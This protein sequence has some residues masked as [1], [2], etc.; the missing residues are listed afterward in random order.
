MLN[1]LLTEKYGKK[2]GDFPAHDGL[3]EDAIHTKDDLLA[4]LMLEHC[5]NEGRGIDVTSNRTIPMFE[6]D[7]KDAAKILKEYIL[8]DEVTHVREGLKWFKYVCKE[9]L[10]L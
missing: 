8:P 5:V 2:Y 10:N 6:K 7:D 1:K 3:W 9:T 4:R